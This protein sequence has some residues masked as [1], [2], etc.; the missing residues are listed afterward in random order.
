MET[1]HE[2]Y[3]RIVKEEMEK[4][5]DPLTKFQKAQAVAGLDMVKHFPI[6]MKFNFILN[7][8]TDPNNVN[9]E[10]V[11]DILNSNQDEDD[12]NLFD[13]INSMDELLDARS[14]C[15][16]AQV[17]N[18]PYNKRICKACKNEFTLSYKEIDF[19]QSK[20]LKTPKR[21]EYCRKGTERPKITE[22]KSSAVEEP[23]P[24]TAMQIALEKAGIS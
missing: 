11:N 6:W 2:R 14:R 24:K 21:C 18:L 20:D 15:I 23:A 4:E 19:Y 8:I 3:S 17:L 10:N 9:W 22:V 13:E 7:H 5:G 16:E 1:V 12:F